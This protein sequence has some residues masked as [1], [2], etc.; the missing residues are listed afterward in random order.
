[1]D[2][3]MVLERGTVVRPTFSVHVGELKGLNK[4]Q[5]LVDGASHWE[6]VDGDLPQDALVIDDEEPSGGGGE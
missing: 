4:T 3:S 6:V 5:G 2:R 1:M